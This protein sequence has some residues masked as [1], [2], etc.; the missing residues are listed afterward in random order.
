[1]LQRLLDLLIARRN[2]VPDFLAEII[3]VVPEG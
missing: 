1:V 2:D 3:P